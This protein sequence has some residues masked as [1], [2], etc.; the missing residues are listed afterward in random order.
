METV[1]ST[2][3]FG[4][5]TVSGSS[6]KLID[7]RVNGLF[8]GTS[9]TAEAEV[10]TDGRVV[11]GGEDAGVIVGRTWASGLSTT[12]AVGVSVL[13]SNNQFAISPKLASIS[14][15]SEETRFVTNSFRFNSSLSTE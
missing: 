2:W 4:T 11:V 10:G 15:E 9:G 1:G 12:A 8:S 5:A 7:G 3:R 14:A 6:P 13:F